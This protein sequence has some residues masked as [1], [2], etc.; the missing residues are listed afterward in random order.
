MPTASPDRLRAQCVRTVERFL[1]ALNNDAM[2]AAR[3]PEGPSESVLDTQRILVRVAGAIAFNFVFRMFD[4]DPR[5]NYTSLWRKQPELVES[6][7]EQQ[8]VEMVAGILFASAIKSGYIAGLIPPSV[9]EVSGD[10]FVDPLFFAA[11]VK[12]CSSAFTEAEESLISPTQDDRQRVI[13]KT[14]Y[15][16]LSDQLLKP[17]I[18]LAKNPSLDQ[19]ALASDLTEFCATIVVDSSRMAAERIADSAEDSAALASGDVRTNG[20]SSRPTS[21]SSAPS[22]QADGALGSGCL[23]CIAVAVAAIAYWWFA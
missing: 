16:L 18:V 12:T 1:T 5:Q 8:D 19:D 6:I 10:C 3:D 4:N 11:C 17:T 22:S 14:S 13:V 21:L 20:A 7:A 9:M 15:E 23:A 2:D